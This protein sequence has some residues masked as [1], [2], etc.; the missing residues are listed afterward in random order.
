MSYTVNEAS[1]YVQQLYAHLGTEM[2]MVKFNDFNEYTEMIQCLFLQLG[3]G[4][5]MGS[6]HATSMRERTSRFLDQKVPV[7]D[8]LWMNHT[9]LNQTASDYELVLVNM[10]LKEDIESLLACWKL[11]GEMA[12]TDYFRNSK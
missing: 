4:V 1:E 8:A 12:F 7:P 3:Y 11:T 6:A 2:T 5:Q 9:W 10:G